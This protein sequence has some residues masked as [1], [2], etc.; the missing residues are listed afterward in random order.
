VEFADTLALIDTHF[1]FT[2]TAFLNGELS[3]AAGQNNGSCKL[4]A[5]AA[6]LELSEA[7]TLACFGH[8]YR[9]EV[10]GDP[11]GTSHQNIRNFMRSGWPGIRFVQPPLEPLHPA[12]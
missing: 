7:E 12:G 2:P 10:L 4:F 5:F 9:D 3:N 1:R 11:D 6:L 8:H